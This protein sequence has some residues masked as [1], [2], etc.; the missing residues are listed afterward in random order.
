MSKKRTGLLIAFGAAVGAAVAGLSYYLR[1]KSFNDELD[2]DFHDYEDSEADTEKEDD[3]SVPDSASRN[4]ITLDTAKC[5]VGGESPEGQEPAA[6]S[7]SGTEENA[8]GTEESASAVEKET[9]ACTAACSAEKEEE[10]SEAAPKT[11]KIAATVEEDTD[12][13]KE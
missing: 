5:H 7:A 8:S 4:Y 13:V 2:Q 10:A 9:A 11:D 1:Y 6:E 12:G 3:V